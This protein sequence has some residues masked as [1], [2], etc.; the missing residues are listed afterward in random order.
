VD[1]AANESGQSAPPTNVTTP[2]CPDTTPPSVPTGLNKTLLKCDK[3]SIAWNASTDDVG[4][5]AYRVYRNGV[6]IA[7]VAAPTTSYT[8]TTVAAETTYTYT[9]SAVDAAGNESAQSSGL[10]VTTPKCQTSCEMEGDDE[11]SHDDD[12]HHSGDDEQSDDDG[13]CSDNDDDHDDSDDD[14]DDKHDD[15]HDD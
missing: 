7:T 8:D 11:L 14:S 4:V 6:L 10:T 13:Q 5:T 3:V 2:A 1:A 12:T 9:V 15:H